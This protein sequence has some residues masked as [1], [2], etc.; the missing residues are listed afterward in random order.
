MTIQYEYKC[1]GG[2]DCDN[3]LS[4]E[5]QQGVFVPTN[6]TELLIEACRR[7]IGY[8][9]KMLD[10]GCGGG[11]VGITLA[12]LGLCQGPAYAS[13][14]SM[15]AVSLAQRNAHRMAVEYVAR[16]GSLFE[17]WA[18]EKFDVI[19]D[20]VAGISDDLAEISQW[21]PPG[22]QCNA[23]RDGV[24]WLM[25]VI[26]QARDYLRDEGVLIFPILSLSNGDKV[27]Q[28]VKQRYSYCEL[29]LKKDWFLPDS[30][31]ERMDILTP[32]MEDGAIRCEKKFGRWI[33]TTYI[34]RTGY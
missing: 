16:C 17:P 32:L 27:L 6:T 33:W 14:I 34:Y 7:V 26:E 23:G 20:D 25:Q 10:L 31:S 19:V 13:D 3:V 15:D 29:I 18:E 1:A 11:V 2:N 12:K 8:P 24:K 30:L 5:T 4:F 9:G 21:Y 28:F 22:V